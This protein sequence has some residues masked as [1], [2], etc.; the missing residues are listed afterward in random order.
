MHQFTLLRTKAGAGDDAS[1]RVTN[2]TT[3][4]YNVKEGRA[5]GFVAYCQFAA[6]QTCDVEVWIH[7]KDDAV[8]NGWVLAGTIVGLTNAVAFGQDDVGHG[9]IYLRIINRSD[10]SDLSIYAADRLVD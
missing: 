10:A 7:N 8:A 2:P 6:A 4:V 1:P 3:G 9:R 5:C